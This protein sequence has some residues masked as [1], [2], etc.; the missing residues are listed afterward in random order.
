[1]HSV[2]ASLRSGPQA[3]WLCPISHPRAWSPKARFQTGICVWPVGDCGVKS[4]AR[5]TRKVGA[6]T[7][8]LSQVGTVST[9]SGSRTLS[10]SAVPSVLTGLGASCPQATRG[11][12]NRYQRTSQP[13]QDG[14][15]LRDHSARPADDVIN[16]QVALGRTKVP[17]PAGSE[18]MPFPGQTLP[19]RGQC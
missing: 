5:R 9:A 10:P 19:R 11:P 12:G 1:M 8:P 14:Q 4:E 15:C 2:P 17:T 7:W 3:F 16:I 13:H 18:H 6:A